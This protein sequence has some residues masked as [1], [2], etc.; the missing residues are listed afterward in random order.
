MVIMGKCF[1]MMPNHILTDLNKLILFSYGNQNTKITGGWASSGYELS[2]YTNMQACSIVGQYINVPRN[3]TSD[4]V[5]IFGTVNSFN[6]SE[7]KTLH[8]VYFMMGN[9]ANSG[10]RCSLG[11]SKTSS[12]TSEFPYG[13]E[14][15]YLNTLYDYTFDITDLSGYKYFEIHNHWAG[16]CTWGKVYEV[17]LTKY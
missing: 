15:V 9:N 13:G 16:G 3:N 17:Y 6:V 14:T 7:Y 11:D 1:I 8:V 4:V 2:G 12:Y 10:L 5:D